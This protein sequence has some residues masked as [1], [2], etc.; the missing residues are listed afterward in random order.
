MLM[1]YGMFVFELKTAPY[2]TLGRSSEWRHPTQS[3]VGAAPAHQYLGPGDDEI[4]LE[5]VLMPQLTGGQ[6]HLDELRGLADEG[7]AWPLIEGSGRMYGWY[8]IT[9]IQETKTHHLADGTA[10]R[11]EFRLSLAKVDQDQRTQLGGM[12][13]AQALRAVMRAFA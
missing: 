7:K 9:S 13:G 8:S 6:S 4:T 1:T 3:R 2:Q 10:Q 12:G 11:I 5:G